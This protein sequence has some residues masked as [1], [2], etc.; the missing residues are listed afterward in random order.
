MARYSLS[1]LIFWQMQQPPPPV[2]H[3]VL[4]AI[5]G[6]YI[7]STYRIKPFVDLRNH[8]C[9]RIINSWM[10]PWLIAVYC[11]NFTDQDNAEVAMEMLKEVIVRNELGCFT[12]EKYAEAVAGNRMEM[13]AFSKFVLSRVGNFLFLLICTLSYQHSEKR[14]GRQSYRRSSQRYAK[15][16]DRS[17]L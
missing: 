9:M 11:K 15:S 7:G 12:A 6:A 17:V 2:T 16:H 3:P 13:L 1:E 5:G 10:R 4:P 14:Y 8:E